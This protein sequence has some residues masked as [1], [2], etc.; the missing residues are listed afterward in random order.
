MDQFAIFV[1]IRLKSGCSEAFL[2]LILANAAAALEREPECHQFHV[3][4]C[5]EN[6]DVFYFFEVYT[7]EAALEFH[8]EQPHFKLYQQSSHSMISERTVQSGSV[9]N[10]ANYIG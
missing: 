10:A 2:P 4:Q 8:R 1:T 5:K 9:L 3:M 7:N 6:L